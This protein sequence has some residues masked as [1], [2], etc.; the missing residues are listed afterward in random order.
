MLIKFPRELKTGD[1]VVIDKDRYVVEKYIQCCG[2]GSFIWGEYG[3][4]H[5]HFFSTEALDKIIDFLH[6][7]IKLTEFQ[8]YENYP[9]V[10]LEKDDIGTY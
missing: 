9:F 5:C 10:V 3:I 4:L 6:R 7:K 2:M 8:T 1:I